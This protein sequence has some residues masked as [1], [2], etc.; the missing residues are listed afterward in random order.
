MFLTLLSYAQKSPRKVVADTIRN[1]AITIDYGAPSVKDRKIWGGLEKYN[2]VWRA[3]ANENT[4]ITFNKNVIIGGKSLKAGK[5]GFFIIPRKKGKWTVIFNTKNNGWGA[6]SYKEKKDALRY[7]VMP[8]F[9]NEN[10]EILDYSFDNKNIVFR[11]E[12]VRL[13]IPIYTSM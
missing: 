11:W 4:T 10:Q 6:Y 1:V 5:Y 9:M 7:D 13:L 3:G 2:K 12:K 8:K